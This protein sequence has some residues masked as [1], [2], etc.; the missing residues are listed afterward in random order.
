[1]KY[2]FFKNNKKRH[3]FKNFEIK[4]KIL[5]TLIC[6]LCLSPKIRRKL[7][8]QFDKLSLSSS[9]T[10][11]HN[12]CTLS[13]RSRGVYSY[14]NLSRLMIKKLYHFNYLPNFTKSS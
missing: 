1:M 5:Y 14:F 13:G 4:Q 10:Y 6:N 2:T 7:S 9:L 3:Y 12:Y 11:I 8:W